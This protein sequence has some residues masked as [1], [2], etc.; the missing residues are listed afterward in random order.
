[1]PLLRPRGKR[2]AMEVIV[3]KQEIASLERFLQN[4]F[5]LDTIELRQLPRKDDMVEVYI[6][7]E[8]IGPVYRVVDE[9]D[10]DVSYDFRMAI[11]QYDL[12]GA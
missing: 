6:G 7:D 4:T 10:G 11:L 8:F 2:Y 1:V 3:T 12:E 9:D 5:R